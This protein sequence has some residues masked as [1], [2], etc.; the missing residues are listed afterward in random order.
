M[1]WT[2]LGDSAWIFQAAGA[3]ASERLNCVLKLANHLETHRIPEVRDIVSSFETLAVH[4]DPA[5]G[6]RVLAWLLSQSPPSDERPAVQAKHIEVPV[7]YD[8]EKTTAF[9]LNLPQ[10]EIVRLHSSAIY[11]VAAV[12]FAP[13]FPYLTGLPERLHL[14][15]RSTPRRVAAGAVAIAGN[16]AGIYPFDSQ[17][18]WHVLGRTNLELFDPSRSEPARLKPGDQVKFIPAELSFAEKVTHENLPEVA[19]FEVIEPGVLCSVQDAGRNG[20]QKIGI[21][22][23]G[24]ADRVAAQVANRLLGNPENA[25]LLEC[26]VSG[27]VLKFSRDVRVAYV[28][29]A[30]L[31]SGRPITLHAGEVLDLRG[32]MTTAHGYLAL[33]GGIDVPEILGSRSTDLRAGFGGWRGR[34]LRAGDRLTLG[35]SQVGPPSGHWRVGWPLTEITHLTL[36]LRFLKGVQSSWFTDAAVETFRDAIYQLSPYSDR[37][38]ARLDGPVLSRDDC[39]EMISQ[40]V[41][42]GSV[43]V[44]PDGR[45]VVL[46]SERQTIGGYP[47]IGHIISA[48]LPKLARALP[49]TNLRFREVSL[50][51]ARAAWQETQNYLG[52][53][54]AG[55]ELII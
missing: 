4:F 34:A 10:Q 7:A 42:V 30:D 20:F 19:D 48:D 43:Q 36:G 54:Q 38:G 3:G 13:G 39:T 21:S 18:G 22:P 35:K 15:R 28:G 11:T 44:P 14:P 8:V 5:H 25:A 50:H 12:G 55:L 53:L 17:G 1:A 27:P 47:Q 52:L 9:A 16:Q 37:M 40:P 29:W 23:G 2:A 45:P 24:T 31:C 33:S 51:E 32:R 26:C 6:E 41:V 46:M 49:G